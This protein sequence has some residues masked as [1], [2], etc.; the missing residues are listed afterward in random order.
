MY[1]IDYIALNVRTF[2][3]EELRKMWTKDAIICTVHRV[4][5]ATE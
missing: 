3:A 4:L 5:A 2:L 1:G